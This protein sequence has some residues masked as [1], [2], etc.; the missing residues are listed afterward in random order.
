[1]KPKRL[2]KLEFVVTSPPG[3]DDSGTADIENA[4][5]RVLGG[6][7]IKQLNLP[8][9]FLSAPTKKRPSGTVVPSNM[10][11]VRTI[12]ATRKSKPG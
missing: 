9:Q 3:K 5:P 10:A 12:L 2:T 4:Y 8:A 11:E 1:M 6:R 7:A